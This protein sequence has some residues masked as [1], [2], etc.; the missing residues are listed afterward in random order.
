VL[1][2]AVAD[3]GLIADAGFEAIMVENFG[4]LPSSQMTSPKSPSPR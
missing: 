3:A 2:A 4:E 1:D